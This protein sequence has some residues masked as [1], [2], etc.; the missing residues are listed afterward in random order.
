LFDLEFVIKG[1]VT[2][3]SAFVLKSIKRSVIHIRRWML[4]VRRSAVFRSPLQRDSLFNPSPAIEAP[5][6]IAKVSQTRFQY[7]APLVPDTRHLKPSKLYLLFDMLSDKT[8]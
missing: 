2:G 3:S 7:S 5:T 4:D 8:D 1:L 6:L